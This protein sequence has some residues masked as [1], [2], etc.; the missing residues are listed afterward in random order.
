MPYLMCFE[1]KVG[2]DGFLTPLSA[3]IIVRSYE[4]SL[5]PG[6]WLLTE[7]AFLKRKMSFNIVLFKA[8]AKFSL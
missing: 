1:H 7:G 6:F 3:C 2:L 4:S 5:T 8:E